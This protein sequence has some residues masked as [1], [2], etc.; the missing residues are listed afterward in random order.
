MGIAVTRGAKQ[1]S[2]WLRPETPKLNGNV[3]LS[4]L[5]VNYLAYFVT[6]TGNR[7]KSSQFSLQILFFK[8]ERARFS[9][10]VF[11]SSA[12]LYYDVT[13]F[14][15]HTPHPYRWPPTRT[16]RSQN[17]GA[18]IHR[19]WQIPF[20]PSERLACLGAQVRKVMGEKWDWLVKATVLSDPDKDH[21]GTRRDHQW[22]H[23]GEQRNLR[24]LLDVWKGKDSFLWAIS[25]SYTLVCLG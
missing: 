1:W 12:W 4:S 24:D 7:H 9:F 17:F 20:H 19:S 5:E 14:Q 15:F 10:L 13:F 3:I 23:R 8:K 18:F 21:N 2:Q 11:E 25:F 16:F 22:R 6:V